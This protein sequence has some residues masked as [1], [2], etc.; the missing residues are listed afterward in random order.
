MSTMSDR[1][2]AAIQEEAFTKVVEAR[3][4]RAAAMLRAGRNLAQRLV[5]PQAVCELLLDEAHDAHDA[6]EHRNAMKRRAE[7]QDQQGVR[8][9]SAGITRSLRPCCAVTRQRP[10]PDRQHPRSIRAITGT[11]SRAGCRRRQ[12]QASAS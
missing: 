9:D 2:K 6:I 4:K 8:L 1:A 3:M 7:P 12:Q 10:G 11:R 5:G